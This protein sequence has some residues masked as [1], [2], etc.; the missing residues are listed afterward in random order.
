MGYCLLPNFIRKTSDEQE[1]MLEIWQ[2][3]RS[4]KNSNT[5][6]YSEAYI[7]L[8]VFTLLVIKI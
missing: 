7:P 3:F 5:N 2:I 6:E 8:M 4:K 1:T